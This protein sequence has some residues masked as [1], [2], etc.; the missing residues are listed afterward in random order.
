[1][2]AVE[3][4]QF[5]KRNGE[6]LLDNLSFHIQ[7]GYITGLIGP[8]GSG[9]TTLIRSIMNLIRPDHGEVRVLGQSYRDK[10]RDIKR[11]IGFV[12]DEDFFYN[13]LTVN[14]MKKIVA[15]FY[16]TWNE[17][18]FR[19]YV[20]DF[21]LPERRKIRDL[22]KGMKTKFA[23]AAAL[24]HEPDLLIMDEPTSGLDPVFRREVLSILSE[25]IQDGSRSVLFSTH[26]SAD[27]ERIADFIV[28]I[29]D[30][31]L[32]FC[33]SKEELID[34]YMLVKGPLEWLQKSRMKD[35]IVGL[36]Q[37]SFGFEGLI[38]KAHYSEDRF[39][40]P[41]TIEKPSLDDILVYT[42]EGN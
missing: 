28:Y 33:G 10:E 23:L 34:S 26:I 3:F 18:A 1:M 12:Y 7:S 5:T 40:H 27:L 37:R 2:N 6:F 38:A 19:K 36:Q 42:K 11:R 31:R 30:G 35:H 4:R 8:N 21:Q 14:E 41:V 16:P 32:M 15:S 17:S 24:A 39:R 22:S 13:H 20:Q 29:R 9:K 25:Y